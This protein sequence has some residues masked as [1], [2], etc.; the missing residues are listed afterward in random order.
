MSVNTVALPAPA[1]T[2][3]RPQLR[4]MAYHRLLAAV[5]LLNAALVLVPGPALTRFSGLALANF[6]AA[7]L[8]RQQTVLNLLYGLAGRGS[9]TWP[10][11]VR[12]SVSKVHHVG[13]IHAG[14][15]LAG[16]AWLCA[17]AVVAVARG[18]RPDASRSTSCCSS[19]VAADRRAPARDPPVRARAHNVF[20]LTHRWGGWTAIALFW[21]L[22]LHLTHG[23]PALA[24]VGARGPDRE[25]RL[26]V[27]AAAPRAGH[28]RAPV[29][30][31]RDRPLRLRRHARRSRRRSASAA[32]RCASGTRSRP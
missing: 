4:V 9:R 31:R 11:W 19:R 6:T 26:A 17:F 20:E 27:A 14:G 25:R 29:R 32:A 22:T 5:L 24:R 7:V 13:G 18:R 8:I 28:G 1:A 12:W 2:R 15:A 23:G 10:L 30:A 21:A 16:T 3:V